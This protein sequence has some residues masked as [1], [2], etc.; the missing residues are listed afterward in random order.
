MCLVRA[1]R[2]RFAT[3][4]MVC[5]LSC[6]TIEV[7]EAIIFNSLSNEYSH[8]IFATTL[9][10][11]IYTTLIKDLKVICCF[12]EYKILNWILSKHNIWRL[13]FDHFN[14]WPNQ[15]LRTPPNLDFKI[16]RDAIHIQMN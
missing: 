16:S 13:I 1:C 8:E 12:L 11:L 3:C 10:K 9:V 4:I 7:L 14:S 15:H 5:K 2:I 6:H